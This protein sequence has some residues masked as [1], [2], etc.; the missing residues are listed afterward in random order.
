[1]AR[2]SGAEGE[3]LTI[4]W[5]RRPVEARAGDSVAA[6][7]HRAG[8]RGIGCSRKLH[9]PLSSDLVLGAQA[10][11]DDGPLGGVPNIRLDR[12]AVRPGLQLCTQ[13]VWPSPRFDL[14]QLARLI[15]RR[16]LRGGF[17][18]PRA[19]PSGS[20]RFEV[21]E[22]MLRFLAGGGD[23]LSPS[24]RGAILPGEKITV[25]LAV[26]G[27]GPAG[28]R[29]AV[30]ASGEG[31]SVL[32]ISRSL[33]P[34]RF[35]AAMGEALPALPKAIRVLAGWEAAALYRRGRILLAA[36]H[37]GGSAAVVAPAEIVLATGRRS[38]A[39]LVPGA[40]LPGVMDLTAAVDL[41]RHGAQPPGQRAF[42]I[43]TS[44]LAAIAPRLQRLGLALA[45]MAEAGR[46]VRILGGS[47]VRGIELS[48][49][50]RI[51][52]EAVIH[53]GPW[54]ADPFLP[55]QAAADGELRLAADGL[56]PHIR[57]AGSAALPPEPV[58]CARLDDRAFVCP[59]MD[60][61][62]AEI[63]DLVAAGEIHVEVLKRL[64]GCGMGPCQGMPCWDNLAAALGHL[65]GRPAESFG[66]P[67]YRA[68]RG[69]LTLAQ[70]AGLAELVAPEPP[71]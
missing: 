38:L 40:D 67:S 65:T 17:E 42:L 41:A 2:R 45:G 52:C 62:V 51:A 35:A 54:R 22:R 11:L 56:P 63:R 37:D 19:L 47:G 30:A 33:R 59:C 60:V 68:P 15:P 58:A 46:V 14:L 31:R 9:R 6:A 49:G 26:V 69:G 8:I 1:V 21:W 23:A 36:P 57:L 4:F 10:Q 71:P 20:R 18:H 70:A 32:L 28:R 48:G 7:L 5:N 53:A 16:W 13:N 24:R 25:D 64:T 12:L 61:T 44:A 55:F 3:R 39:P 50:K 29:A 27:G 66:H 34:G 43:G